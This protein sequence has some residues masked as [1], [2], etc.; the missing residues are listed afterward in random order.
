M[1]RI[2]FAWRIISQN[3]T[4]NSHHIWGSER[5]K[6]IFTTKGDD[7]ANKSIHI[8]LRALNSISLLRYEVAMQK[9]FN[10]QFSYFTELLRG[11][12][13]AKLQLGD[14]H[15]AKYRSHGENIRVCM[16]IFTT[17]LRNKT[18]P[19]LT[20]TVHRLLSGHLLC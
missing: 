17:A 9:R 13:E 2:C 4:E 14:D 1:V 3:V 12:C 15:P 5:I 19:H 18:I 7:P 6:T 11:G 20:S 8:L 10:F 16:G